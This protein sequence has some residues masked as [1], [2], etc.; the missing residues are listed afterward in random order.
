M[1]D[2]LIQF[3][4]NQFTPEQLYTRG[5]IVDAFENAKANG[6]KI[7][8]AENPT[9]FTYNRWNLGMT[10]IIP[11]FEYLYYKIGDQK[12]KFLGHQYDYNGGVYHCPDNDIPQI[13]IAVFHNGKCKFL[14]SEIKSLEDWKNNRNQWVQIIRPGSIITTC[15]ND[16]SSTIR[17]YLIIE[18]DV[19]PGN[20]V[21]NGHG[22]ISF[23]SK[24]AQKMLFMHIGDTF[25][26]GDFEYTITSIENS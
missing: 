7:P 21:T 11:L 6:I 4:T 22:H 26:H 12:Y 13:Q 15:A 25:V 23:N 20:N 18:G 17:K 2:Q 3:L 9:A 24:L 10:E 5:E 19:D 1:R 14:G 8:N 16:K